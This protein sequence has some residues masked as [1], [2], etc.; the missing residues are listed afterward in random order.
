MITHSDEAGFNVYE[1]SREASLSSQ[2]YSEKAFILARGFV[3]HA[4]RHNIQGFED[5]IDWLYISSNDDDSE[6]TFQSGPQLLKAVVIKAR[7][8]ISRSESNEIITINDTADG[9]GRVSQGALVLLRRNLRKLEA[10]LE[11]K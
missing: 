3:E 9:V 6:S 2:L 1:G 11:A 8:V 4:L 5:V 10:I 7:E